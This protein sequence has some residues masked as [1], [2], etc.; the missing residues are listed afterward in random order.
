[1][2][3]VGWES[4]TQK[5]RPDFVSTVVGAQD[6][7]GGGKRRRGPTDICRQAGSH[8]DR[9]KTASAFDEHPRKYHE[10][11]SRGALPLSASYY[12]RRVSWKPVGPLVPR[13]LP[14]A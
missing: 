5:A 9:E 4:V 14:C 2:V 7:T 1:V 8:G 6:K 3:R 10:A 11:E 12:I 13:W